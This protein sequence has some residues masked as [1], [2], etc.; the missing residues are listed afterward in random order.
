[1]Q[2]MAHVSEAADISTT[3]HAVDIAESTGQDS[4]RNSPTGSLN[5]QTVKRALYDKPMTE[6]NGHADKI[7]TLRRRSEAEDISG[8]YNR[9][10]RH[11]DDGRLLS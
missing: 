7:A 2:K 3:S 10:S 9:K 4:L 5:S 1:M 6:I 8:A 11:E